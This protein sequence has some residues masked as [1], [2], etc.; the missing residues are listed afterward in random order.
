MAMR[1]AILLYLGAVVLGNLAYFLCGGHRR[2]FWNHHK[3]CVDWPDP[4]SAPIILLFLLTPGPGLAALW[5]GIL[6]VAT[7]GMFFHEPL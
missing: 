3:N 4:L 6:C 7:R 1:T 5:D 2:L